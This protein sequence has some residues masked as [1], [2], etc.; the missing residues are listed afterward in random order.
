MQ[1]TLKLYCV[2]VDHVA[3]EQPLLFQ[4][5][6][7]VTCLPE[8][9][10]FECI[11]MPLCL[12]TLG[13]ECCEHFSGLLRY[14]YRIQFTLEENHW[15][16]DA[17]CMQKRG[18]LAIA[19]GILLRVADQPVQVIPFELVGSTAQGNRV[20][21]PIELAPARNTSWNAKR[22]GWCSPQHCRRG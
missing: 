1:S 2:E 22:T 13:L 12:N 3:K 16:P 18:A 5:M 15:R 10:P 9:V 8:A 21:D 20:A 19:F 14:H 7:Q 6:R 4:R 17:V 11:E